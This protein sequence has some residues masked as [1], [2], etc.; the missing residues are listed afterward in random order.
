MKAIKIALYSLASAI[1]ITAVVLFFVFTIKGP[2]NVG[3]GGEAL[4]WIMGGA[5][6]PLLLLFIFRVI[7]FSKKTKPELKTK[8]VPYY[9]VLNQFHMPIGCLAVSLLFVHFAMVFDINDPSWIH[10]ITGYI[11]AG[12]LAFLSASGL[13][14][15]FNKTPSRKTITLIHQLLVA[16]LIVVFILHL[17]LK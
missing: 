14:A 9:R 10:F 5:M 12:L 16:T 15:Y 17:V 4:G 8:L 6:V 13:I 3:E 1:F 2:M 11:L 7:F